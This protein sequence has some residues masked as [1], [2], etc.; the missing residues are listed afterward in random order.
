MLYLVLSLNC[1]DFT[2]LQITPL[3]LV[4]IYFD[5]T[6]ELSY[7]LNLKI[8]F[9]YRYWKI[10]SSLSVLVSCPF[11][12][13]LEY[14][15]DIHWTFSLSFSLSKILFIYLRESR[16][17]IRE[18]G[19]SR[20]H[21]VGS[22]TWGSISWPWDYD[23]EIMTWAKTKSQMFYQLS[24]PSTPLCLSFLSFIISIFLL[25]CATLWIIYLIN[26]FTLSTNLSGLLSFWVF[27]LF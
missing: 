15:L 19:T 26:V 11:Y 6:K 1:F 2:I 27:F 14:L 7:F 13:V 12:S 22:P 10:L 20:L 18:R 17:R 4:W 21:W 24:H 5:S 9:F 3:L 25:H 23:S 8:A 16:G